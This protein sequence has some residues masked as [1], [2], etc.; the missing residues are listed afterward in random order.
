MNWKAKKIR[1]EEH[2]MKWK[3]KLT[4]MFEENPQYFHNAT[5]TKVIDWLLIHDWFSK[6]LRER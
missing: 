6:Y 5:Q 3:E 1:S 4:D 2:E